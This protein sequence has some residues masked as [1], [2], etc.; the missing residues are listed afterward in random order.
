M[1]VYNRR[2]TPSHPI[3]DRSDRPSMRVAALEEIKAGGN[4][5]KKDLVL[6]FFQFTFFSYLQRR[7]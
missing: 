7:A 6:C 2:N 5:E 1:G 4:I 3:E